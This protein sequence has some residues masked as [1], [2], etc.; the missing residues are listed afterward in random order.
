[1]PVSMS[2]MRNLAAFTR[3][4]TARV[5]TAKPRLRARHICAG[6]NSPVPTAALRFGLSIPAG[7]PSRTPHIHLKVFLDETTVLTG[8]VYCPDDL[9]ARIYREVAPYNA[10]HLADM[11]NERDFL[12]KARVREG[13]GIVL[14]SEEKDGLIIAS[15]D[16]VVDRSG[17]AARARDWRRY[18]R[19]LLGR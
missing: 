12:F 4:A 15:L 7:I 10:R 3:V 11:T 5:T 18:M 16:I 9:S 8:Q 1:M 13:G 19:E 6:R 2:G 17:E 14:A